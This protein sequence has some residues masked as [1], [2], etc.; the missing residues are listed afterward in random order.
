MGEGGGGGCVCG[1]LTGVNFEDNDWGGCKCQWVMMI[2]NIVMHEN[3]TKEKNIF[4]TFYILKPVFKRGQFCQF[5]TIE[6]LQV[7]SQTKGSHCCQSCYETKGNML[8]SAANLVHRRRE[9]TAVSLVHRPRE[10]TAVSCVHGCLIC[11]CS[12]S[13]TS[14]SQNAWLASLQ[15][16]IYSVSVFVG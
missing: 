10:V 13:L 14:G 8:I 5:W 7:G 11:C 15:F 3:V 12:S 1:G 16:Y 9:V 6:R 2:M 4:E